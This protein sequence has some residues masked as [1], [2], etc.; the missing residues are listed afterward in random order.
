M[1]RRIPAEAFPFASSKLL[2]CTLPRRRHAGHT[3]SLGHA[4]LAQTH[5]GPRWGLATGRTPL[6]KDVGAVSCPQ[7]RVERNDGQEPLIHTLHLCPLTQKRQRVLGR[8]THSNATNTTHTEELL[9]GW[10]RSGPL[11][12]V[13]R[14]GTLPRQDRGGEL[15]SEPSEQSASGWIQRMVESCFFC[16]GGIE[17]LEWVDG[18]TLRVNWPRKRPRHH[19]A[20]QSRHPTLHLLFSHPSKVRR[21]K[22]G[23]FRRFDAPGVIF[24]VENVLFLQRFRNSVCSRTKATPCPEGAEAG[25]CRY[26]GTIPNTRG[27]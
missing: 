19:Q 13:R 3:P 24:G 6:Q 8:A 22:T 15:N 4:R 27:R 11:L 10:R 26:P 23:A 14:Y 9:S 7:V 16:K 20:P 21:G 17:G 1:T 12:K 2:R 5:G 25:R 18:Q